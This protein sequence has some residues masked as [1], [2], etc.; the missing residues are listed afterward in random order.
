MKARKPRAKAPKIKTVTVTY[1]THLK[2]WRCQHYWFDGGNYYNESHALE[3]GA[4]VT[5]CTERNVSKIWARACLILVCDKHKDE[6]EQHHMI[7]KLGG[8]EG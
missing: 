3:D 1:P 5:V 7:Q 2:R 6:H 4:H 8:N